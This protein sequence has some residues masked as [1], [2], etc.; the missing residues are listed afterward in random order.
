M[1]R[2]SSIKPGFRESRKKAGIAPWVVNVPA[3]LS[4]RGKRQELFFSSKV[5]AQTACNQL[6]V[7]KDNF[8]NALAELSS[9]EIVE[10]A[11]AYQMLEPTGIG[12]VEAVSRYLAIQ[13][14]RTDS[15]VFSDLCDRYMDAKSGKDP[16]HL[17]GLR[18][19]KNRFPTL[20]S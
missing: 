9:S 1:A 19:T 17:K 2:P 3:E 11:K 4:E 18:N 12:L 8:G 13:R 14:Q 20:H 15:I 16:R 6:K 7:R 5:E 10:A